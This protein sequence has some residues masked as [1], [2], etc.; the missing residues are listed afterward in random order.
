MTDP[1]QELTASTGC[2]RILSRQPFVTYIP[3]SG[4]ARC[5]RPA[6]DSEGP[7]NE[8]VRCT[9]HRGI[10]QRTETNRE[11]KAAMRRIL[12]RGQNK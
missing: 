3:P 7:P 10:D 2:Q 9:L 5:G 4:L 1:T 6:V 11:T 12:M 8:E